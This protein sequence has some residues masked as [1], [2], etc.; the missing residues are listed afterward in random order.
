[1]D[2]ILEGI[3]PDQIVK[4]TKIYNEIGKTRSI[5]YKNKQFIEY[6]IIEHSDKHDIIQKKIIEVSK[7]N[8][9]DKI[10]ITE[11]LIF[12]TNDCLMDLWYYLEPEYFELYLNKNEN[13]LEVASI[14]LNSKNVK[15]LLYLMERHN[16]SFWK[17]VLWKCISVNEFVKLDKET[18]KKILLYENFKENL[19]S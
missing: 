1:M 7:I 10:A 18:T 16:V 13:Y 8:T 2:K 11:L 17:S 19:V 15:N 9:C 5:Y 4:H 3:K 6:L 14:A 12:Y